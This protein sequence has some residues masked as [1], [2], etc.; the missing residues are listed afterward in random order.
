MKGFGILSAC[1]LSL[2]LI[3]PVD[4]Q[5]R[6]GKYRH[7]EGRQ[8]GRVVDVQPIWPRQSCRREVPREKGNRDRARLT[9]ALAGGALGHL[10]G[11]EQDHA[12][13]GTLAG[14]DDRRRRCGRDRQRRPA[15]TAGGLCPWTRS[16]V[17]F[18]DRLPGAL[19][20]SGETVYH[21]Y[22]HPSGT[23]HQVELRPLQK[24]LKAWRAPGAFGHKGWA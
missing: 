6:S 24:R 15:P 8:M 3:A 14:G 11:R 19:S 13:L 1:L 20:L 16:E 2:V 10:I 21:P 17:S 9:G 18:A 7:Q 22:A 4:A 23:L 12:L 5:E